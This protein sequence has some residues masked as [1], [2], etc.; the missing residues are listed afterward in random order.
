MQEPFKWLGLQFLWTQTVLYFPLTL[1]PTFLLQSPL[2][3]QCLQEPFK[4]LSSG[5]GDHPSHC[6]VMVMRVWFPETKSA[7]CLLFP[8]PMLK[9]HSNPAPCIVLCKISA[10]GLQGSLVHTTLCLVS[11]ERYGSRLFSPAARLVVV[12]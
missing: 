7:A 4:H 12:S 1:L 8:F 10:S 6:V 9:A 3:P 2:K 5:W 11:S